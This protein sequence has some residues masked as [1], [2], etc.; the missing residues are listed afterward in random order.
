MLEVSLKEEKPA[1]SG[2]WI[3]GAVMGLAYFIG[4]SAFSTSPLFFFSSSYR[5]LFN[6]PPLQF[7]SLNYR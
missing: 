2:A 5:Q 4:M 7:D 6:L 1:T 3:E